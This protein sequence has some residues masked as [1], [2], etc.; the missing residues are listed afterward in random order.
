M[1]WWENRTKKVK[2]QQKSTQ[3][4]YSLNSRKSREVISPISLG[5]EPVKAL[6]SNAFSDKLWEV[7]KWHGEKTIK[8]TVNGNKKI[9]NSITYQNQDM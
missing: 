4:N 3:Y 8:I 2:W 9:L 6:P 5:M 1:A 7:S